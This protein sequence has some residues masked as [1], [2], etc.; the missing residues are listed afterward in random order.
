MLRRHPLALVLGFLLAATGAAADTPRP[1]AS[2]DPLPDEAVQRLGSTRFRAE[3]YGY[4]ALSPDGKRIAVPGPAGV[5][6]LD[7]ESGKEVER[8]AVQNFGGNFPP[9]FSPDGKLLA[10]SGFQGVQVLDAKSGKLLGTLNVGDRNVGMRPVS[11]S[12]D[13]SR[14]AVGAQNVNAKLQVTVWDADGFKKLHSLEVLQDYTAQVALSGDGKL[15]ATW[16]QSLNRGGGQPN[17][18]LPRTVQLWD[19]ATGKE[20]KKVVT[21]GAG[22]LNAAALSA[23]GKQLAALEG[24]ASLGIWDVESGKVAHRLAARR[25]TTQ[26]R[27]SPDGKR[28]AA[29]TTDGAVQLWEVPEY[30]RAG[31]TAG[32]APSMPGVAAVSSLA[33]LPDGKVRAL[34]GTAQALQL[35]EAPS[36]KVLT[37]Q[38][39]PAGPV[40]AVRFSPDGKQVVSA[41]GDGVRVW[42]AATGKTE[43]RVDLRD[44]NDQVRGN[45]PQQVV[46]SPD[47]RSLVA[48]SFGNPGTRMVDLATGQEQFGLDALDAAPNAN[49]PNAAYSADGKTLA[50]VGAV[51]VNPNRITTVRVWDVA[52]GR[53]R[54]ALKLKPVPQQQQTAVGVSPDGK[55]VV[56]AT[57]AFGGGGGGQTTELTLWDVATAKERWTKSYNRWTTQVAFS[58]DGEWI[59]SAGQTGAYLYEA[60]TGAEI[61]QFDN[62]NFVQFLCVAFSPDGRTLAAGGRSQNGQNVTGPVRLWEVATGKVRAEFVGHRRGV[63]A[64]AFAPDGR[65]LASGSEDTTVLLWDLTGKLNAAAREVARPKAEDFDALWNDLGGGGDPQKAYRLLQGLAAHP[66]EAAALVKAKLPAAKGKG[67][68]ATAA[69][70]DKLIAD[71]DDDD[72]D[73]REAAS[74]ALAAVGPKATAALTKALQGEPSVEKKERIERLLDLL[75]GKGPNLEAVRPTRALELLERVGTPEAKQVLE[76]LAKGDPDAPLTREARATLQRLTAP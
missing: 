22:Y 28:L 43:K 58:P 2:G 53:E 3:G 37:P 51:F 46:L 75:K 66:A 25:G 20:L 73:K 4:A 24:T 42:N 76:E 5:V 56:T 49:G 72:F 27:Y 68:G 44:P 54:A 60:A 8:F 47:G 23:D 39:A 26:L 52:A 62:A 41:T 34:G 16:G 6:L 50:A 9:T 71:L 14:I 19:T 48:G 11:F 31:V 36:G 1:D 15:L 33:F 17:P 30:K 74:K 18:D 32:P 21:E 45:Q 7:A 29:T 65:V 67:D 35:W 63:T 40:T 70:I 57:N 61:R 69:E 59:A 64:L 55:A 38:D 12:A 13:G 10:L